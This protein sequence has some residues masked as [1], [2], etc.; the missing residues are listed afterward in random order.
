MR[1]LLSLIALST[2]LI[3]HTQDTLPKTLHKFR[4][5]IRAGYGDIDKNESNKGVGSYGYLISVEPAYNFNDWAR[6]GVQYCYFQAYNGHNKEVSL[7]TNNIVMAG[8]TITSPVRYGDALWF[9][10]GVSS[11]VNFYT[12]KVDTAFFP[13]AAGKT[14]KY[15]GAGL[16]FAP[17]GGFQYHRLTFEVAYML[18]GNKGNHYLTV[19]LGFYLGG[20]KKRF[21]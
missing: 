5:D 18:S 16:A 9:I 7:K 8:F 17:H 4:L 19:A 6:A 15:S 21:S 14:A 12:N 13:I 11:G 20:G 2:F 10:L 1:T 3:G